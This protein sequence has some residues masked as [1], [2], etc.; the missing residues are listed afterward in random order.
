MKNMNQSKTGRFD[1]WHQSFRFAISI[2]VLAFVLTA[3]N[4][5]SAASQNDAFL[6]LI[7]EDGVH[8]SA[9]LEYSD[10]SVEWLGFRSEISTPIGPGIIHRN[11]RTDKIRHYVHLRVDSGELKNARDKVVAKYKGRQYRVNN[12]NCVVFI[13]EIASG[14][15]FPI[16]MTDVIVTLPS[17]YLE[18]VAEKYASE[19]IK[20]VRPFPWDKPKG[21]LGDLVKVTIQEIRCIKPEGI[22]TQDKVYVRVY[23]DGKLLLESKDRKDLGKGDVWKLGLVIN[24]VDENSVVVVQL[25][26]DDLIDS[27]DLL[28]DRPVHATIG[29][30]KI[31]HKRGVSVLGSRSEYRVKVLVRD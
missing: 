22:V 9:R 13:S 24:D 14:V 6:T 21:K 2:S 17:A 3:A 23:Q 5:S 30:H 11:D 12:S 20:D 25:W 7:S 29:E 16:A 1:H 27:D 10:G 19:T 8:A 31:S 26:D 15:G 18:K 4:S 28:F